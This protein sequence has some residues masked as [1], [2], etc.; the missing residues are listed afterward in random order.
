MEI[1]GQKLNRFVKSGS[2]RAAGP[3][4]NAVDAEKNFAD[5]VPISVLD[6]QVIV[7]GEIASQL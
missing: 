5:D 1:L 3:G 6:D 2:S 4:A 7:F